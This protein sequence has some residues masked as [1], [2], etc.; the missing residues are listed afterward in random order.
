[1]SSGRVAPGSSTAIRVAPTVAYELACQV[2][3]FWNIASDEGAGTRHGE[4]PGGE[5]QLPILEAHDQLV[6]LVYT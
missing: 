1:M 2:S 4:L 6:A 5:V 3:A